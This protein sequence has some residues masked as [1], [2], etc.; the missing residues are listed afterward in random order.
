MNVSPLPSVTGRSTKQINVLLINPNS[1]K[2]MTENCLK[3]IAPRL[4]TH[5]TVHGF[6]APHPAPSAIEGQVDGVLST[7][8]CLR[9]L[10]PIL[11]NYD[12]F[13]VSCFS[14]HPLINA[15]REEVPHQ[16]VMGIM[17]AALYASRICGTRLSV[18]TTSARSA[19]LHTNAIATYGFSDYSAGCKASD[20]AV[21]E[22]DSLPEAHVNATLASTAQ[23]LVNEKGADC[24]CLGCAGM[25]EMQNACAEAVNMK[26]GQAM[27]VDGVGVGIHFLIALVS[28]G[29]GTAKGGAYRS[30]KAGRAARGQDW[31]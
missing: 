21:L 12:A 9:A 31:L 19:I 3:S 5:V 11:Q 20:I 15:L 4:P 30:A 26:E 1:T 28:E 6:T 25:T 10:V 16:P 24:I 2:S 22:L 13:L 17:E 29:L 27:V 8:V 7:A 14:A 18:L 23:K